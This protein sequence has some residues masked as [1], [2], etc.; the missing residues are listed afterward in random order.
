MLGR[1]SAAR[2]QLQGLPDGLRRARAAELAMQMLNSFG[3]DH[4]ESDEE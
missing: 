4:E 1:L 2:Q 3:L